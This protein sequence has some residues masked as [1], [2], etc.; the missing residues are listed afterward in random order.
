MSVMRGGGRE[1]CMIKSGS[2][3]GLDCL[4]SKREKWIF[5]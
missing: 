2:Y 5:R 3:V 4:I 1:E